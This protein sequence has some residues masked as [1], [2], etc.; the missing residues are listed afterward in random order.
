MSTMT[1]VNFLIPQSF[2]AQHHLISNSQKQS[3]RK[4]VIP[5]QEYFILFYPKISNENQWGEGYM[6]HNKDH[7]HSQIWFV[8]C[9]VILLHRILFVF[10]YSIILISILKE[11]DEGKIFFIIFKLECNCFTMLCQFLLYNSMNQLSVYMPSLLRDPHFT[12]L[13][14]HRALG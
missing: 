6:L 3:R 4:Q 7:F 1:D 8:S 5:N 13:D 14:H 11:S 9:Q 10:Y 12:H 2:G